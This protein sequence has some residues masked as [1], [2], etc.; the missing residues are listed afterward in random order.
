M[1]QHA[2]QCREWTRYAVVGVQKEKKHVSVTII[3]LV[4]YYDT[5]LGPDVLGG[6]KQTSKQLLKFAPN[7]W[8]FAALV[9]FE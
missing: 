7:D 8:E 3:I 1:A 6:S 2:F 5:D 4:N 9:Y